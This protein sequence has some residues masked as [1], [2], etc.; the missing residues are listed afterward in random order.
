[1]RW[2][3]FLVATLAAAVGALAVLRRRRVHAVR[4]DVYREDGSMVSLERG[5]PRAE[6][7]LALAG[8]AIRAARNP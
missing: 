8:A 5:D 1:M 6:R 7:M 2:R 3:R 4:V